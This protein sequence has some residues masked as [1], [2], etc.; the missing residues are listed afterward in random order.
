MATLIQASPSPSKKSPSRTSVPG[1]LPRQKQQNFLQ[2]KRKR[3]LD[4]DVDAEGIINDNDV[5]TSSHDLMQ[6]ANTTTL[7]ENNLN[8]TSTTT[9]A[10][11]IPEIHRR[12]QAQLKTASITNRNEHEES[13][14]DETSNIHRLKQLRCKRIALQSEISRLRHHNNTTSVGN[15]I[16]QQQLNEERLSHDGKPP[17]TLSRGSS[18][19]ALLQDRLKSQNLAIQIQ[20]LRKVRKKMAAFRLA[21]I[22]IFHIHDDQNVLALRY[23]VALQDRYV[24]CYHTF[25]DLVTVL[26]TKHNDNSEDRNEELLYLRLVQHTLPP[27]VPLLAILER[28]KFGKMGYCVGKLDG[29]WDLDIVQ[30]LQSCA[31]QIYQ[32]CFCYCLRKHTFEYL[33]SLKNEQNDDFIVEEVSNENSAYSQLHFQ[34]KLACGSP[35]LSI[36][37]EYKDHF[38]E[39]PSLVRV[40]NQSVIVSQG[41]LF[42]DTAISDDESNYEKVDDLCEDVKRLLRL[43]PIERGIKESIELMNDW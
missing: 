1:E 2:V 29:E 9:T 26:D 8:L 38:R 5:S 28:S 33:E 3:Q 42:G 10:L 35:I 18:S 12:V 41:H 40:I 22:S 17:V 20:E 21:G 37:L 16:L 43:K 25:F 32:A 4:L 36:Q 19:T 13:Y 14:M 27:S 23:D 30:H 15:W 31:Q 6:E 39:Q 7:P 34:L 24:A 11:S